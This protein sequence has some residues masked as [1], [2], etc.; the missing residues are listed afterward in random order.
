HSQDLPNPRYVQLQG[1]LLAL[2]LVTGGSGFVGAT[3][4]RRL[5]DRGAQ[6]RVLDIWR[7][8]DL[9]PAVELVHA[10]INDA[11]A[12]ANAMRGV[13]FV[14]HNVALVPLHKAG[15]RYWTVNVEGTAIALEAARAA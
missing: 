3:I 2:H 14:H 12:V 1:S 6:V 13:D 4:A 11:P 15:G 10:D 8:P 7:S 5:M 9:P